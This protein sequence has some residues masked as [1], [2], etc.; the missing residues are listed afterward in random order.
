M[1]RSLFNDGRP[2]NLDLSLHL[3]MLQ[4]PTWWYTVKDKHIKPILMAS[5]LLLPGV[6]L[7][8][9][10]IAIA[11]LFHITFSLVCMLMAF[12]IHETFNFL[13]SICYCLL[14]FLVVDACTGFCLHIYPFLNVNINFSSVQG[15]PLYT[16]AL[17]ILS[18]PGAT[19]SLLPDISIRSWLVEC[20]AISDHWWS[21]A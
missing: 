13:T 1:A 21:E 6:I 3:P 4:E 11:L 16:D 17:L 9:F 8:L 5:S 12:A 15:H 14:F 2:S 18:I 20:Q 19:T 10:V 7:S